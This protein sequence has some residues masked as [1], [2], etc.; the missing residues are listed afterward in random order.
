MPGENSEQT[1]I[2]SEAAEVNPPQRQSFINRIGNRVGS[3]VGSLLD[4]FGK[5]ETSS[6][7][8]PFS[9]PMPTKESPPQEEPGK[10]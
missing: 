9:R 5:A 2:P 8:N 7:L 3:G 10:P 6:G 1:P 4:F